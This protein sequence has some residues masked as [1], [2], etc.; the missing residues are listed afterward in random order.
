MTSAV[1]L[2]SVAPFLGGSTERWSQGVILLVLSAAVLFFP[3]RWLPGR[4]AW[5]TMGATVLLGAASL[6]PEEWFRAGVH[7]RL[8]SELQLNEAATVVPQPIPSLEA[9]ALLVAGLMWWWWTQAALRSTVDRERVARGVALGVVGLAACALAVG[10]GW[11]RLPFWLDFSF[12]PFPNRNQTADLFGTW[13]VVVLACAVS[14]VRRRAYVAALLWGGGLGVLVI[15]LQATSSRAGALMVIAGVSLWVFRE[16]L[17]ASKS[18]RFTIAFAAGLCCLALFFAF[19]TETLR[20]LGNFFA[21]LDSAEAQDLRLL[22]ARDAL[23]LIHEAPWCG[24]GLGNFEAVFALYRDSSKIMARALH[25]ES[26]WLWLIAEMGWLAPLLVLAL[27]GPQ[28]RNPFSARR[29]TNDQERVSDRESAKSGT[30]LA[31]SPTSAIPL[32]RLGGSASLHAEESAIT[33]AAMIGGMLFLLHGLVDVSG[34]RLGSAL[35]GILLLAL[36]GRRRSIRLSSAAPWVS[37][38]VGVMLFGVGLLWVLE[39]VGW[40]EVP[41]AV[42]VARARKAATEANGREDFEFARRE[43]TRALAWAPLDWELYFLRAVAEV[44]QGD[45]EAAQLDF[46]RARRLEPTNPTVPLEEGRLWA[47]FDPS[48]CREAWAE[49]MARVPAGSGQRGFFERMLEASEGQPAEVRATLRG[50]AVTNQELL[51]AYLATSQPGEFAAELQQL[52]RAQPR[53]G[54]L[55]SAQRQQ[56]FALWARLGAGEQ[57]VSFLGDNPG[58]LAEGWRSLAHV[59]ARQ[60]DFAGAV[61]L[62]LERLSPPQLPALPELSLEAARRNFLSSPGDMA[63]GYQTFRAELEAGQGRDA[64][65]TLEKLA[66]FPQ[67]PAYVRYWR[68]K[69]LAQLGDHKGAWEA[70]QLAAQ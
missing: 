62:S 3:A 22:L 42:A 8:I 44:Y 9:L 14:A 2:T 30:G 37:S 7:G 39:S 48:R 57:L 66:R 5:W 24:I 45:A 32:R 33:S 19:G 28:L 21:A 58:L 63:A 29:G 52:L 55:T 34:H 60:G 43:T 12:G 46:R 11:L 23:K 40:I 47:F 56:W 61:A 53:L 68:A 6:L 25:P 16:S 64:L 4:M 36:G 69:L 51:L 10:A 38:I 70:L 54:N 59:R 65:A 26:D 50:L 27:V 67:T 20:R 41:G 17:S 15:A 18:R 1:V 35:P 49:V 31:H 13:A